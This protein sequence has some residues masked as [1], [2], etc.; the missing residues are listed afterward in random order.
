M[1]AVCSRPAIEPHVMRD[2]RTYEQCRSCRQISPLDDDGAW[3]AAH[4]NEA[5]AADQAIDRAEA[6]A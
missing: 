3:A 6:G 4:R 1:S 5:A 2:G